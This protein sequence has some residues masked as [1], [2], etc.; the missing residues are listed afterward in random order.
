MTV[1]DWFRGIVKDR[2]KNEEQ[3]RPP[4][5]LEGTAMYNNYDFGE[6]R[7]DRKMILNELISLH[8][9]ADDDPVSKKIANSSWIYRLSKVSFGTGSAGVAEELL[10]QSHV[11]QG[12]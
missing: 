7:T 6:G 3:V 4:Q 9:P 10:G 8:P 11:R 5:F 1:S 12:D 2:K